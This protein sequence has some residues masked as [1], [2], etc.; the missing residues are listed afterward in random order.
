[1]VRT[2]R[3][4]VVGVTLCRQAV[5]QLVCASQVVCSL[6][7]VAAETVTARHDGGTFDLAIRVNKVSS[8]S[9]RRHNVAGFVGVPVP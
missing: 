1:M 9:V 5:S 8:L 3:A 4:G 7:V 6:A 2:A